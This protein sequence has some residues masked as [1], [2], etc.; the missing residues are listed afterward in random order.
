VRSFPVLP[1]IV[2]YGADGSGIHVIRIL[3]GH[4][5]IHP[6]LVSLLLAV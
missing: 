1:Y 3:Y 5:D 4:R 6:P 2:F